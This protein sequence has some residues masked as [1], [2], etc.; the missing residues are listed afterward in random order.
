MDLEMKDDSGL[1]KE[2]KQIFAVGVGVENGCLVWH[3]GNIKIFVDTSASLSGA[4][5]GHQSFTNQGWLW[6]SDSIMELLSKGSAWVSKC[7]LG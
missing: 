4:L 5:V 6:L 1:K 7:N 3:G 2:A